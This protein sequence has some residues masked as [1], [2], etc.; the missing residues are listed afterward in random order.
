MRR[1]DFA[2]PCGEK[3]VLI[4]SAVSG[5]YGHIKMKLTDLTEYLDGQLR[6]AD[7]PD[8]PG[9]L[10]GLQVDNSGSVRRIAAAVDATQASIDA[11]VAADCD[12]LLV[13]HGLFWDGPGRIVGR[14]YRRLKALLAN[15][16]AVYS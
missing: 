13:H 16:L 12:L 2:C 5:P 11:A 4:H 3:Q 14:R 6:I 7:V 15:D 10:N 1:P 9:A 8:Y